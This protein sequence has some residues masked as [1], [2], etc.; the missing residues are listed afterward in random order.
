DAGGTIELHADPERML[1]VGDPDGRAAH[2]GCGAALLNL[3]VAAAVAGLEADIRLLP[4]PGQPRLLALI[5]LAGR[6]QPTRWERE[7]HAAIWRRQTNREPFSQRAVPPGVRA[8]LAEAASAEGATLDFL[9]RGEAAR[10]LDLAAD[11][12]RD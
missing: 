12:E 3:R 9:D 7:L 1:P 6:H 4:D 8:E 10:V 11:A 5:R 2:I